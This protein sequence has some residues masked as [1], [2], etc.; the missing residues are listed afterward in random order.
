[1]SSFSL[2][3][4]DTKRYAGPPVPPTIE[5]LRGLVHLSEHQRQ[6]SGKRATRA[7]D[8]VRG[9]TLE[10]LSDLQNST[11]K[12]AMLWCEGFLIWRQVKEAQ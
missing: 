11:A 12:S 8:H 6:E 10:L 3:I 9:I 7:H 5:R 2:S 4:S 1:M